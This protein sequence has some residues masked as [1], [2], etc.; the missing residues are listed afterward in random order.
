[1]I[2]LHP[3]YLSQRE[4]SFYDMDKVVSLTMTESVSMKGATD[5]KTQIK[6]DTGQEAHRIDCV[7][8]TDISD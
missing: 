8:Q 4:V 6:A 1:M 3:F 5:G 7:R 2:A